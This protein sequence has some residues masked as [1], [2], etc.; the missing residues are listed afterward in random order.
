MADDERV[1]SFKV[2]LRL[3]ADKKKKA[4]LLLKAH[5][6][7]YNVALRHLQDLNGSTQFDARSVKVPGFRNFQE[8]VPR[9]A[10]LAELWLY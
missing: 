1:F 5:T 3:D 7:G 6:V 8:S 10:P 4:H 9:V 2:R